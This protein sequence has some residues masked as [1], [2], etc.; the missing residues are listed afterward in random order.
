MPIWADPLDNDLTLVY[1]GARIGLEH[2]WSHI[3]ALSLQHQLFSQMRPGVP[4]GDGERFLSPPPAAWL[5]LPLTA[6]GPQAGFFVWL[7]VSVAAL[8][9][10]WWLA[11]PGAGLV[12]IAWLLGAMAWYPVQYSLSLGQPV[13]LVLLAVVACWRLAESGRPYLAGAV[14]G[15]S[16]LKPQLTIA[17]PLVLIVAGHWRIAAGWA[18]TI[19]VLGIVS[20]LMVG[21][22]GVSD[23]RS[24]L[25]EA[26]GVVN[27]RYFTWAF[28][29]GP[30]APSYVLEVIVIAVGGAA[31]Y[32]NRRAGMA[33]LIVLGLLTSMLSATYWHL[34]D[35]AI[36]VGAAWLFIHDEPA[37]WQRAWL[38]AVALTAELAWPWGP[39]PV[40][41]AVA[42]WFA[43]LAIPRSSARHAQPAAL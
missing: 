29:V 8:V 39:L 15:L 40:L 23:Y 12:R 41:I 25:T 33:R 24:L 31:A 26:Q 32:A 14:L 10:A 28:I 34:Q 16:V 1:I 38:I 21:T 30:G 4:F 27:N 22:Q 37:Q 9:A 13:T 42:V 5:A 7:A 20:L 43:L 36:L 6:V 19:A 35:F 3:Y 17:V 11:A 2:G 18:V